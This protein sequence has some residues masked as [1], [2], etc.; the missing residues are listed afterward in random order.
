MKVLLTGGTGVLGRRAVPL[1][2]KAGHDVVA[3]SRRADGDDRLRLQGADPLRLDVFDRDAVVQAAQGVDAIVNIATSIPS[4]PFPRRRW[5]ANDRLR[6]DASAAMSAAAIAVGARFVQESFAPAYPGRGSQWITEDVPLEPIDQVQ[7]VVDAE[8]SAGEVTA[9][10]GLGVVLRFG[11]FYDAGSAQT[12]QMLSYARRGR[13]PLPGPADAYSS[14]VHVEDAAAA[15]VAALGV[16]AGT[17]NVVE[18]E[19]MT[20]AAHAAVLA[21][22]LGRRRV[23]PLP[24][25]LGRAPVLRVLARSQR[26]SNT[27]LTSA[28]DWATRHPNVREGWAQ[29]LQELSDDR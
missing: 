25:V 5:D 28:S 15:V 14:M 1:L 9:A 10:G 6:R 18:D 19:P 13:L 11:L 3:V 27:K 20:R 16:P 22:L 21:D 7:T 2:L 8:A 24:A 17:Y 26:I 12:R 4:W 29:V 23:R